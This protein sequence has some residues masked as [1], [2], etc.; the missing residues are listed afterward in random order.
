MAGCGGG[1]TTSSIDALTAE[2]LISGTWVLS[3]DIASTVKNDYFG[4]FPFSTGSVVVTTNTT[5]FDFNTASVDVNG[6]VVTWI[7]KY[8]LVSNTWTIQ[9]NNSEF[10][11]QTD[12]T[13]LLTGACLYET[14]ADGIKSPCIPL[15]G[16][17]KP[18][19]PPWY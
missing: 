14:Q 4:L 1:A 9:N 7:V 13:Q 3:Y 5:N 11:F 15:T 10:V 6:I 12:G 19:L 2:K 18:G 8:D 16:V 17:K